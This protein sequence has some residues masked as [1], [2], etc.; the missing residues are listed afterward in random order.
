MRKKRCTKC[1]KN[2][3]FS[4]FYEH[5]KGRF[6]LQSQCRFCD[7]K[8]KMKAYYSLTPKKKRDFLRIAGERVKRYRQKKLKR[9]ICPY[10]TRKRSIGIQSC[11]LHLKYKTD[12]TKRVRQHRTQRGL[13]ARCGLR[14]RM[15]PFLECRACRFC[16]ATYWKMMNSG[17]VVGA[18]N[19][20][21]AYRDQHGG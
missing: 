8:Q 1:K 4:G 19:F 9:G 13:C 6:G 11:R 5:P 10:C 21:D 7:I 2:I 17:D 12:R 15:R 14:K 3:P 20:V 18:Q 16:A